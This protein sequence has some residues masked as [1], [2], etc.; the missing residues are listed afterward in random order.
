MGIKITAEF[1]LVVRRGSLQERNV[2]LE[3]LFLAMEVDKPFDLSDDLISFGPSFGQEALDVFV[4]RL[5]QVGLEYFEDFFEFSNACPDWCQ[6]Q[7]SL[8]TQ[9][10][11]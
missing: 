9:A 5:M 11:V 4:T 6:F 10:N 1:G 8:N 7:A 2:S 3:T